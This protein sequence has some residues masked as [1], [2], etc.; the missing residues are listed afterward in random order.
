VRAG[1]KL[2]GSSMRLLPKLLLR[3]SYFSLM[4]M[5]L[6]GPSFGE[7]KKEVKSLGKDIFFAVDL[8]RSMDANDISPSRLDKV[9]LELSK[10]IGAFSGDRL[11]LIIFT[12]EAFMQCPLTFDHDALLNLFIV[13]LSTQQVSNTGTD[14]APPVRMAIEKM[15]QEDELGARK[16]SSKIVVLVSD[17]EDFGEETDDLASE[18]KD[19]GIRLFTL[20]VGTEAGGKIP[21]GYQFKRDQDGEEV[22]TKLNSN[23]LQELANATDGIYFEFSDKRSDTSKLINAISRIEGEVRKSRL[24]DATANKYYYFLGVALALLAL[25]IIV[26]IRTTKLA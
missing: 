18:L 8:S 19:A 21:D 12:S 11:G 17:G 20:G 7:Q 16:Q 24:M 13:P 25:D 26:T 9:K 5:A 22:I 2:G 10:I 4:I 1:K 14:F 3:I 23:S 15:Q 6:L